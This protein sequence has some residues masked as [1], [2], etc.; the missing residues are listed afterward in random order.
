[1]PVLGNYGDT[2]KMMAMEVTPAQVNAVCKVC[3]VMVS[4][5]FDLSR[6]L[7]PACA[8]NLSSSVP[9]FSP[10]GTQSQIV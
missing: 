5:V 6:I 10:L 9:I 4:C 1:M 3:E 2:N 7:C 8:N